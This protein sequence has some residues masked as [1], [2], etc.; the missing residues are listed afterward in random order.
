MRIIRA[1]VVV[2]ILFFALVAFATGQGA[3]NKPP[4]T[5]DQ[6]FSAVGIGPVRI[7]PDGQ[8]VVI[9]TTRADWAKSIF[10]KDIW[11]YRELGAGHNSLIPLTQSE[12]DSNPQWS[13]DGR[14]IAFLSTREVK[15]AGPESSQT[16]AHIPQVYVIRAD[17]GEAIRLTG[18]SE[19]VHAFAWSADSSQIFYATRIP[20]TKQQQDAYKRE[21]HDAVQYRKSERGDLIR[22]VPVPHFAMTP[23]PPAPLPQRG[24]G[25]TAAL[26][27]EV[28]R[29]G[30]RAAFAAN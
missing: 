21:W 27:Q 13:P 17:G 24:E 4:L 19:P 11:L 6:F 28:A 30:H 29:F 12:G 1:I 22:S 23:S 9:Q 3:E 18:G 26:N 2:L 8:S 15:P 16:P 10:R 5:L 20:W 25:R 14:W 7:S